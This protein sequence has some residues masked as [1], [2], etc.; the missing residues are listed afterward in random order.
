MPN[1]KNVSGRVEGAVVSDIALLGSKGLP[2]D[3]VTP[4]GEGWCQ[5]T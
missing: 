2:A 4:E 1:C 5:I 3:L